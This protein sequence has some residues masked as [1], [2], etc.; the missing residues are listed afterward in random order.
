MKR[1]I[2]NHGYEKRIAGTAFMN[3]ASGHR[4]YRIRE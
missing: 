4:R 2:N 3:G 1:K